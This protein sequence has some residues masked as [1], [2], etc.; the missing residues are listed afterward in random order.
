MDITAEKLK[1]TA[2]NET[3]RKYGGK[4]VDFHG[5]ELPIQFEGIIKEHNAVR[6]SA[7][8]LTYRTWARIFVNGPTVSSFYSAPTP[9][10]CARPSTARECI[11]ILPTNMPE[12]VDDIIAFC[13]SLN[14][15]LVIVNATTSSKDYNWLK[16]QARKMKVTVRNKS[17]AY[18]MAAVQGPNV[19]KM[20]ETFAPE[21]LNLPRFGIAEK[22]LFRPGLFYKPHRLHR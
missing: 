15:Y 17:D 13:L 20:F 22:K 2:L 12:L 4:M 6:N 11:P 5:W 9:T 8:I 21:A 7:G 18:S 14:R 19:P 3:C 16:S 10:T 1:R